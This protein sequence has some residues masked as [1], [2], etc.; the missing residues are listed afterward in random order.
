MRS[1]FDIDDDL[2]E[3]DQTDL[4]FQPKRSALRRQS[5]I[6][7]SGKD[8][9]PHFAP[10]TMENLEALE[11]EQNEQMVVHLKHQV[12]SSLDRIENVLTKL[13]NVPIQI[14]IT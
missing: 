8:V 10:P 1:P 3:R 7:N 2:D 4:I 5:T 6:D 14:K 11:R 12:K 9:V 13:D